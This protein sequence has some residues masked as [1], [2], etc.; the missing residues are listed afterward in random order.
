MKALLSV[1]SW[2]LDMSELL[3]IGS[4]TKYSLL[5]GAVAASRR[6][7]KWLLVALPGPMGLAV[8]ENGAHHIHYCRLELGVD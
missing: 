3:L 5:R 7:H 2:F 4:D 1:Q 8:V 6:G